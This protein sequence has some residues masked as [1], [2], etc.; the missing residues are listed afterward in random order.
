MLVDEEVENWETIKKK[1]SLLYI[2]SVLLFDL[3]NIDCEIREMIY[4]W[5]IKYF[6]F[7]CYIIYLKKNCSKK[8]VVNLSL[9]A[10]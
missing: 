8:I 2:F 9:N 10:I 3:W 1:N 5:E 7:L 4:K 6:D